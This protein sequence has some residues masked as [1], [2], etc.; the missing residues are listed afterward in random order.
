MMTSHD[1]LFAQRYRLGE[2]IGKGALGDAYEATKHVIPPPRKPEGAP[3]I[4]IEIIPAPAEVED[5][6]RLM[7]Y[8]RELRSLSVP[9]IIAVI[10][11]GAEDPDDPRGDL[12]V[13]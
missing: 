6:E 8:L 10:D 4:A 3:K 7:T 9:G 2:P 5:R 1:R 13:A 12:F 11:S